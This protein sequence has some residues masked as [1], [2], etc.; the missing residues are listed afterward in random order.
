VRVSLDR[1]EPVLDAQLDGVRGRRADAGLDLVAELVE[2]VFDFGL[3]L[4]A[5]AGAVA[6]LTV[7]VIAERVSI[8]TIRAAL[9]S[10]ALRN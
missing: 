1:V 2:V 7:A 3:G 4:A 5:D 10:L 6:R 8:Q 9:W